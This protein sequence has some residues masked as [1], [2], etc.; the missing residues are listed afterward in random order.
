MNDN[1]EVNNNRRRFLGGMAALAGVPLL[2]T[3]YSAQALAA[4]LP[5]LTE[6]DP[7]AQAL[8]YH[9]NAAKAPRTDKPDMP[10]NKQFC[11]LVKPAVITDFLA[12][13]IT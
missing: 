11:H 9:Q 5:H 12:Y 2:G 7:T 13:F 8:H 1:S 4:G 3:I 10:A 6:D